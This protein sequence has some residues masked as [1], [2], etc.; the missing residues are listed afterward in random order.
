[1]RKSDTLKLKNSAGAGVAQS[2]QGLG[3][4][5]DDRVSIPGTANTKIFSLHHGVQTGFGAHPASYPLNSSFPGG[6]VAHLHLVSTLR[7]REAVP[8]LPQ[9]VF[10]CGA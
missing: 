8:P 4:G 10:R 3:Y 7:M 1:M 9:H 5:L 6:K 2:L